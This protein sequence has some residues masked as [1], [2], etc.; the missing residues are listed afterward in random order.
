MLGRGSA[1]LLTN[2]AYLYCIRWAT[3][4]SEVLE[5]MG[6]RLHGQDRAL[7]LPWNMCKDR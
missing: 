5:G 4:A 1:V 6:A 7:A 2:I 3:E